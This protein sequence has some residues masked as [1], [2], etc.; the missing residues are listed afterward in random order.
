MY[1]NFFD[2]KG[3]NKM[4]QRKFIIDGGFKTDDASELLANLTM[5]GH[6]LPNVDSNGSTGFDLGSTTAKWRDL[7]LSEGSLFINNQ[8]VLQDDSGT[9]VVSADEDQ[10]LTVKTTGTGVLALQSATTVNVNGTLQI[11]TGNNITDS[12]GNAVSFGDK[13]DMNNNLVTNIGTAVASTDAANKSYVDSAISN[14]V[15]G[16]PGAMDTLNEL[17]NAMGDDANFS[18]TVTNSIATNS[19]DIVTANTNIATNAADIATNTVAI[20]SNLTAINTKTNEAYVDAQ[21]AL[22]VTASNT[23]ADQAEADAKAYT[24]TRETAINT[25]WAAADSAQTSALQTYADTAEAD[26]VSAA[27]ATASADATSKANAAEVDAKAYT[28]TRETAITTAYQS[29]AD[30]AEA[31]AESA[32]AADATS[33]ANA[34][35]ASAQSYADTAEAD[36][37][38]TAASDATSKA[39]AA[40]VAAKSYADQAEADAESAAATDAT[41]KANAA[42]ASAQ[43][44][45]DTAESDAVSTAA[46][47]ATSKANAAQAAAEATAS[48]DATAK[49]DAAQAAAISSVTN[50]AG[51]AF[52]T[53]K[54]IQ[55]AMATDAELSSAISSVTS[56]AASTASAG[57]TSKA[58]AAQAA[59]ISAAA[60][61]ATTKADAAE[62]DAISTAATD[63]TSKANA[64]QAAAISTAAGDATTKA[65]AALASALAA[66]SDTTYSVGDGGLTQK[67]FTSTLK[68]KLDGIATGATNVTNNNQLTNGAGYIT[69]YTDTN[70][71]YTAGNGMTLSGTEFKMSGSYTGSFTAT[72]DITAYSDDSLKTNVQ[73]IDGALGRVE[74]IRGVTFERI[75]DG[76]V[77]TGVIAQELKAVLPEAVHT[78]AEGVHSVA[79]GNITGLLIEAVKELSAQVEELKKK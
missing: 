50:G 3:V 70:T 7:Y 24:D 40:L 76:S 31:D 43:T 23:Y 71:T 6:I 20:A 61:D 63:A 49:A 41:T 34:A 56:S 66:D 37:I 79:Y 28:D 74:A 21:M 38:S 51:A 64:A 68:T 5:G 22:N 18:T 77:S 15:N 55:D 42:L 1:H 69:G 14:L 65:N 62:A 32:A 60:T 67:N 11:A 47:D 29:Y 12:A 30:Q 2:Q 72:G 25:A 48:A 13:I 46:A 78:D 10:G 33:K 4:A 57:A 52:D 27:T 9:I 73:V 44:Y 54:E 39:D 45:A 17:A 19:A 16:A 75:E 26:A 35:L 8:K 53:L 36:A 58:N 59:A